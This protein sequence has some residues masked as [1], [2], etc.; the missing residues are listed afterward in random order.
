MGRKQGI[1][2]RDMAALVILVV[3]FMLTLGAWLWENHEDAYPAKPRGAHIPHAVPVG[4]NSASQA[5]PAN[6][7]APAESASAADMP[8][9]FAPF[10]A[11]GNELF[12]SH[13]L[14]LNSNLSN[15]YRTEPGLAPQYGIKGSIGVAVNK[16]RKGE[17]YAVS[18][19]GDRFINESTE[20]FTIV[21]DAA[22]V[23]LFPRIAYDYSALRR[24]TQTTFMNLSF[25]V[26]RNGQGVGRSVTE[27]WQVHQINDCPMTVEMQTMLRHGLVGTKRI[28]MRSTLAGY[29]NENHPWIDS[30]LREAKET[31]ICNEFIGYQGG[32]ERIW[33]QVASIWA[34]LQKRGLSYSSI[35]TTTSS[36]RFSFQHVRFLDQS[37]SASQANC[38]DGSVL[39]CSIL[40]KIGLNVGIMLVPGHAYV[41]VKDQDNAHFITGIETTLLSSADLRRATI[42]ANTEGDH[43]LT[44]MNQ[45]YAYIDI[46]ELRKSG[47]NPIPFDEIAAMPS[48]RPHDRVHFNSP[49][50]IAREQR[51]IL[52]NRL[53]QR[54]D[55]L[56]A[57]R[58]PR[59]EEGFR[60]AAHNVFAE[61]RRCQSAFNRLG[62]PPSLEKSGVEDTD[63]KLHQ[64]YGAIITLLKTKG[65]EIGVE[66]TAENLAVA[67]ELSD[68]LVS[69]ASLPLNY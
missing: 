19:V 7:P 38:V 14:S 62:I 59:T 20:T 1:S 28:S 30:I 40:R 17:T 66:V 58:G 68:A 26:R 18:V 45:D 41:C 43:P 69:L 29:V 3:F 2:G 54:V 25:S 34:A 15:G 50:E 57:H 44:K 24:N 8:V 55:E 48:S 56:I 21:E 53:R 36:E 65:I 46:G 35:A 49:A 22:V 9:D 60:I 6:P 10:A 27:K 16:V 31:G 61:I 39:L 5:A 51:I 11:R 64:R 33:P 12:P 4:E 23:V 37:I 47:R 13:Q 63:L 67:K 32:R 42:A 52:A